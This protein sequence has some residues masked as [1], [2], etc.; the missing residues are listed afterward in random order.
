MKIRLFKDFFDGRKA[1]GTFANVVIGIKWILYAQST[2]TTAL[3]AVGIFFQQISAVI[4]DSYSC[5]SV[6]EKD[7]VQL[8]KFNQQDPK[9]G[10]GFASVFANVLL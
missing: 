4:D 6:V 8:E 5:A 10:F 2:K 7:A 1:I 3:I 9:V